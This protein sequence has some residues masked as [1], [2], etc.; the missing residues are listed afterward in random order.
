[1]LQ[2]Q[3]QTVQMDQDEG[4]KKPAKVLSSQH[5]ARELIADITSTLN[6]RSSRIL[7]SS[8]VTSPR[9]GHNGSLHSI[10]ASNGGFGEVRVVVLRACT[11][12]H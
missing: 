2:S 3:L 11:L 4:D 7:Q 6:V 8:A 9:P 5:A 12:G 1:M 10:P